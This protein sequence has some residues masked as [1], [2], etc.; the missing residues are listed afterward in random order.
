MKRRNS[1]PAF[2]VL[3]LIAFAVSL[4]LFIYFSIVNSP[5]NQ[6][7]AAVEEFYTYEQDGN[8]AESW[9]MFHPYMKAKFEK[10]HYLQDRAHVFLN[11]FGVQTFEFSLEDSELLKDFQIE[12]G[13]EPIGEVY[14][15]TVTQRFEGKY[16]NFSIVQDV[17]TT[18]LDGE[19]LVLWDYK[20]TEK[21]EETES[22]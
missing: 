11:H 18:E 20:K 5:S 7:E 16:G 12:D 10:G 3:L 13:V 21:N 9:S 15:V 19:W 6:A 4:I 2:I 14:Q 22:N 1:I 17:Y 8:F